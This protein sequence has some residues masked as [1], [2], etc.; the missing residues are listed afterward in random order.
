MKVSLFATCLTDTFLPRVGVAMVRLLRHLGCEVDFP[1]GQTCCGQPQFN[2]GFHGEALDLAAGLIEALAAS[3]VVV[4]PSASC[5]A[6]IC[7][8]YEQLFSE[9]AEM[10]AKARALAGKTHEVSDF[11]TG[12][13]QADFSTLPLR[14]AGKVTYHFACHGRGLGLE[15]ETTVDL[16]QK[17]DGIEYVPLANQEQ[18]CGFGGTFAVKMAPISAGLV[19]DK[20]ACIVATGADT[21]VVN[22]GGCWINIAGYCHRQGIAVRFVH[23]VELLA[24]ALGPMEPAAEGRA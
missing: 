23:I 18:C 9:E 13:L 12:I 20:V 3:D 22:D 6:M 7:E 17:I 5:V 2:S 24:E 15:A 11:L 21:V 1:R 8:Y 19:A 10:L 14:A 16:I 4:S